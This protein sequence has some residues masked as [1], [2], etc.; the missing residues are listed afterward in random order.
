MAANTITGQYILDMI[1]PYDS[2][3][4]SEEQHINQ[5]INVLQMQNNT[6]VDF[7]VDSNGLKDR[8]NKFLDGTYNP[9]SAS[10]TA[11]ALYKVGAQI[12]F[13]VVSGSA[14]LHLA[15]EYA[16]NA[17]KL[18]IKNWLKLSSAISISNLAEYNRKSG[19]KVNSTNVNDIYIDFV[20][21]KY[22]LLSDNIDF[23]AATCVERLK[24]WLSIW[25]DQ[26]SLSEEIAAVQEKKTLGEDNALYD[27]QDP[28]ASQLEVD[29]RKNAVDIFNKI[30]VYKYGN[31][32]INLAF[33]TIVGQY[34]GGIVGEVDPD[35]FAR[36]FSKIDTSI[37]SSDF[38]TGSLKNLISK[39]EDSGIMKLIA[40]AGQIGDFGK[41]RTASIAKVKQSAAEFLDSTVDVAW[42]MALQNV[43]TVLRRDSILFSSLIFYFPSI[44]TF[45]LDAI[46]VAGDYSNNGKGGGEEDIVNNS[47][48]LLDSLARAFG[49]GSNGKKIFTLAFGMENTANRI[50]KVIEDSPFRTNISPANPD[51]FHLRLGAANFYVPPVS[52]D[53][54]S[55]FKAGSLMSSAL[56]QKSSPK[57]NSGYKETT[58]RMR[59]FFP[60]YEQVWGIS[61]D[62]ASNINLNDEFKI[63]FKNGGDSEIKIDKFLSSLR[64]L[65][66]AFKYSPF[67]PIKNHYLNSV[68]GITAVALSSMSISTIPNYPFALAVDLELYNFNHNPFLPM[69]KDFN[70]AIH[71]GKYRQYIGKAAG[72][73]NRYVNEEFLLKTSD[74]KQA[75]QSGQIVVEDKVVPKDGDKVVPKDSDK[76]VEDV[77][78]N[79]LT[80]NIIDQWLNGNNITLFAPA[81]SQTKLFLP[82]TSS[83]RTEQEKIFTDLGESTW[84]KLLHTIGIDLDQSDGYH[85][86]LAETVDISKENAYSKSQKKIILDA[87]DLITAGI[88]SQDQQ[89]K[90]YDYLAVNFVQQNSLSKEQIAWMK[91]SSIGQR[92]QYPEPTTWRFQGKFINDVS[93]NSIKEGFIELSKSPETFLKF[94]KDKEIA[95]IKYRTGLDADQDKVKEQINKAFVVAIYERFFQSGSIQSLMEA[96]RARAGAYQFNEWEVPMLRVDLDPASV[97]VNGVTVSVSNNLVKMQVQMQDEPTYQHI[98][99]KDS[100]INISMTVIGE[101]ELIKLKKLF[102][103]I[104]GLARLEHA[105]GVIG[106]L[107][108]KNII[109]ALAGIKYVMPLSYN[110]STKPNYPHVYDVALTLVDFDIFQQKREELSSRQ[111]KELV[112]HFST[113]KNPFLRMK[114]FWGAFNAYPDFPLE[115]KDPQGET[116]GCLDPDFYFRS[117]EMFDKD[118]VNSFTD[119]VPRI[120]DHTF[121]QD[122]SGGAGTG[123]IATIGTKLLE[124]NISAKLLEFMRLY[125]SDSPDKE[126]QEQILLN[127]AE[128]IKSQNLT[129]DKFFSIFYSFVNATTTLYTKEQRFKLLTDYMSFGPGLDENDPYV[130]QELDPARFQVGNNSSN[131]TSM[132]AGIEA[133]LSGSLNETYYEYGTDGQPGSLKYKEEI[134]FHPDE[135]DFH[136]QI[137]SIP[138]LDFNDD[139]LPKSRIPSIL[140]TALGVYY[141]YV[142][143]I[144]GRFYL[145]VGGE[146][147]KK[148]DTDASYKFSSNLLMDT[149]TPDRGTKNSLTGIPGVAPLSEY[150]KPYNGNEYKHWETMLVDTSYRDISGRMLR[151]FPTYMIWLID[152]GG[153]FAGAKLFD[154]FYGL[155]SIIDFSVVASEDLLGDTLVFRVSNLY[156]KITKKESS[157]LFS[158]STDDFNPDQLSMSEGLGAIVDQTLN[159]SRN[160]LSGMR[161]EYIVDIANIRLKPGVRVHLRAGYGSNPN[162]LQT[163]F[164]GVITNVEQGEIVTVTAQSD[165]IELGAVVNSTNKKGD[166]GKIDGGVDT[167]MY[168]S[169][170]RDLMVRLLS[171]GSSRTR[172]AIAHATLG[173]I[174][175][176]NKFGIRHFGTMIYNATAEDALKTQGVTDNVAAAFSYVGNGGGIGGA[177][178]NM[179][180]VGFSSNVRGSTLSLIG[181]MWANFSSQVDL[182]IFKR[183]IYAGNGL[184][185]AQFM[186]GDLDDGWGTAASMV[187]DEVYN[188]RVDGY[189]GRL[190]DLSYNRLLESYQKNDTNAKETLENLTAEN[191]L[192]SS[193]RSGLVKGVA[194]A[195]LMGIATAV[196]GPVGV[197]LAGT[198]LLGVLSGRG[199]TNVFRALGIISPNPDDDLPG[200][201]E[202]S[203]RAQ[204]YMRSVWDLFQV[205]ARLL[206]N[207]IVAVRP[208]EDRSTV[209]YG[210]P[211][212]LYTSGIVPLTTGFPGEKEAAELGIIPPQV[213]GPDE[214][215]NKILDTLN[216][217]TNPLS[218]YAAYFAAYEPNST[219]RTVAEQI[220]NSTGIYSPTKYFSGKLLNFFS[221]AA[222]TYIDPTL[223]GEGALY[224][225]NRILAKLPK[226]KGYVGIGPHLPIIKTPDSNSFGEQ[227]TEGMILNQRNDGF[228]EQIS[229]LPPRY[230]FPYFAVS[231]KSTLQN[232]S[233]V[234][235]NQSWE[236]VS[237][238]SI[239]KRVHDNY[240]SLDNI[241]KRELDLFQETKF[242]LMPSLGSDTATGTIELDTPLDFS[243]FYTTIEGEFP[244]NNTKII[245]PLPQVGLLT[246]SISPDRVD[247]SY[248][249]E[250][251]NNFYNKISYKEWGAPENTLEEQF[252]IAMRWP[253]DP[254]IEGNDQDNILEKFKSEYGITDTYGKAETYKARRVLVY[255]PS[256]GRAVVCKPAYFMWGNDNAAASVYL[257]DVEGNSYK[258]R[259][260][261]LVSPDAAYFLSIITYTPSE[262]KALTDNGHENDSLKVN[263]NFRSSKEAGP[264][265]YED[266]DGITVKEMKKLFMETDAGYRTA[267]MPQECLFAFVPDNVPL[268]VISSS[269]NPIQKF[270]FDSGNGSIVD[271]DDQYI[272]GF[273][274]FQVKGETDNGTDLVAANAQLRSFAVAMLQNNVFDK[275]VPSNADYV[276]NLGKL[277]YGGNILK[278]KDG[279]SYFQLAIDMF[280]SNDFTALDEGPL[281]KIRDTDNTKAAGE[282]NSLVPVYDPSDMISVQARSY[283]DE[284][285]DTSINA[286]AGNGRNKQQAQEIW[287][288]FKTEYH[289]YDSVKR[290]FFDVY[291]LDPDNTDQFP[292]VF[293]NIIDGKDLESSGLEK[294]SANEGSARDEFSILFG[295]DYKSGA[296][297]GRQGSPSIQADIKET[298]QSYLD[299]I[300]FMR[301]NYIDANIDDGGL[302]AYYDH[303]I[304]KSLA[305]LHDN[306]FSGENINNVLQFSLEATDQNDKDITK[307]LADNIKTPK[308]LFLLIVGI[309]R[310]RMWEDPYSRAWVVLK[311]DMKPGWTGYN[312]YSFKSI[313]PVFRAFIDPYGDYAK[314]SKK[315]KF[316]QLLV[317]TKSEGNSS[318]TYF[319]EVIEDTAEFASR[320]IGPI[321]S[322]VA[323]G[324][325]GLLSMF[326]TSMQQLGYALSEVGNFKKQANIM[327]KALNDS[328]YYS[329]GRPGTILRAVDNPFSREYGEPVIEI[330]EP[331]QRLHYISSF[332]HILTNQIQEN[333]NNVATVVTAVSDGK[334]PVSVAL[335]KGAPAE[336]QVEKTVETGILFDNMTGSGLFGTILHPFFH[337]LETFRGVAKNVQGAPDELSARRIALSHL[338]ESIKDIYGGELLVI[339]NADIRPHDLV[340]L[341]DVYER[342]YGIFEVEQVIHHFT[343]ELGFITS[344]TPNALV[345]I[346]DPV[347][348]FM[349][350]WM[351]SWMHVQSI[352][353]DTRIYIDNIRNANSG[354]SFGGNVS[355]DKLGEI[356]SSQIIGGFQFTHGSS[357][358]VKDVMANQLASG[359]NSVADSKLNTA[360][361]DGAGGVPTF[362][363]I[364]AA[365]PGLGTLV[366]KGW[367]WV[368]D[369]VLDQHGCYVQYL[370]KNGQPMDAGLSYNQGMVVGQHH[371]KSLLPG[372]LGVR[373]K[374]R[375]PEG[376][377]FVRTDDLLKSL[378]WN[379]SG[380]TDLQRHISYESALVHAR[381]LGMSGLGPE[382][383]EFDWQFRVLCRV[384]DVLD[385]DT[386]DVT[387]IISGVNFRIRFDGINTGETNTIDGKIDYPDT[388]NPTNLN[389]LDISTPGGI[390]KLYV[391][392]AIMGKIIV[393]RINQT[394]TATNGKAVLE[395]DF[396]AGNPLNTKTNY[397]LDIF[398]SGDRQGGEDISTSRVMGTIFY[399]ITSE[400]LS[401]NTTYISN[402]FRQ[403]LEDLNSVAKKVQDEMY[404]KSPFYIKFDTILA[405]AKETVGSTYFLITNQNDILKNISEENKKL[406]SALLFV[407]LIEDIYNK[408][409]DWPRISWDEYY[410]DGFPVTLNWELVVNNLAKVF[411]KDLQKESNSVQT[412]AETTPTPRPVA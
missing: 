238:S 236:L 222:T 322:A 151:A 93:L 204:T 253:Y 326:K 365:I 246:G 25:V 233:T 16:V 155:Q 255:N 339:G 358:L 97:I 94:L 143:K 329:L 265:G 176:E 159:I 174:F 77:F 68:H 196:G 18:L 84:D 352:R 343:P 27:P 211:H 280:T 293:K 29:G 256:N 396:E 31:A 359:G 63:D 336:R 190:T 89:S 297:G 123:L 23:F 169:E 56:R 409:S 274:H 38:S 42:L 306:F 346:N 269:V 83:F 302:I 331:F 81:E 67:L 111:Q 344:I 257:A 221:T 273:G 226:S 20:K 378:G 61:I 87:I 7:K 327:N 46:A 355:M 127:M 206:P 245:M 117:F 90:I 217:D 28:V 99:G 92:S 162:S 105:S 369:N 4:I 387:D 218:D 384:T 296:D 262:A 267:P 199:G 316:L 275:Y 122:A 310:Q 180:S 388:S 41:R 240:N 177:V 279:K 140:Q 128:Y 370:N 172:E 390:A 98:G 116:V 55:S 205:C 110:V 21:N 45:I 249:F 335:D 295:A 47:E 14:T 175:S 156:S 374:A 5:V 402:I 163:I 33:P 319:K 241:I 250:Y 66:A 278:V 166:S 405:S 363:L 40:Y 152:E 165:A 368:R 193:D 305:K 164:N 397:Q 76:V 406:Y 102:D 307:L 349:T 114:Q 228:H 395:S 258:G 373:A 200:F 43:A 72:H 268:G 271:N 277:N 101:K 377:S 400:S 96:A 357:A 189:L 85:I 53:V 131:D 145:T 26:G 251:Q 239:V 300:E 137:F 294:F 75:D 263:F 74:V 19:S 194:G 330:R 342:M 398:G 125:T 364:A 304:K 6:F 317:N 183:N 337:P 34:S 3:G 170:P 104:S 207:Y 49:V 386:I 88:N 314:P 392:D 71:W 70:Q 58:I 48:A 375:T 17:V 80:T 1:S 107:G 332:S 50:K 132:L 394:R 142:D 313:D 298:E 309:F 201:D 150:Q 382:K 203:F 219:F 340:Y 103:H 321:V 372:I 213:K 383:T 410:D 181:Q 186:G 139:T 232:S 9:P 223:S 235:I 121:G 108:I 247:D 208:F 254:V 379:E 209:F 160:I 315:A 210:K 324:L 242:S 198:G 248:S 353:N 187:P 291:G 281:N 195:A 64:G 212:W 52:I 391:K 285:F 299:A 403:N 328:I 393:V 283:Y 354:L 202:V 347:R 270:K 2:I 10:S 15:D 320:T 188:D 153:Y 178:D 135:V 13:P 182:E 287:D 11:P 290:I 276:T 323:D 371:S 161:N 411:V 412:S 147:V 184:G 32:N 130:M 157:S 191:R 171:M 259:I 144:N 282:K 51:I 360:A 303:I 60:N 356:L 334:Y 168:L 197:V 252:Y 408:A 91:D 348:W 345:T 179:A 69:I 95:D 173:T 243:P 118:V 146:S 22:Y 308:Q 289:T 12:M 338:K 312:G 106:F 126:E 325:S 113:K 82:S 216:R 311:P 214:I 148:D 8:R 234:L 149:Q 154:N 404:D 133:A 220:A 399:H 24:L 136:A 261:A 112:K 134:S 351:Q 401:N 376:N 237:D 192:I 407:K 215:Y 78:A 39:M 231:E 138:A 260:D 292:Q 129:R 389:L 272:V 362:A 224:G 124:F 227:G 301:T 62:D 381:V 158:T 361:Q 350:S 141:G 35:A 37:V 36:V 30:N 167:G 244:I 120:Q 79:T 288:T 65:V 333:L 380:I 225:E 385:G 264:E 266:T 229:N 185:I 109:T 286:I 57:F 366:W 284:D 367:K 230:G 59:L 100:F 341:S 119:Q 73:M 86:S 318:N 54:N 44:V 115:V